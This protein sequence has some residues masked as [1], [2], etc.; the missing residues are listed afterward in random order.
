MGGYEARKKELNLVYGILDKP[1]WPSSLLF[2][3]QHFL[4]AF[5]GILGT[6]LIILRNRLLTFLFLQQ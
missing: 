6:P 4:S 1:S 5:S 3:L 2:G